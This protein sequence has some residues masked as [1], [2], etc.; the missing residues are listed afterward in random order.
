MMA[1]MLEEIK[2]IQQKM[3]ANQDRWKSKGNK[4][5]HINQSSQDGRSP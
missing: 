3:D 5:R 4:R 2:T 1:R